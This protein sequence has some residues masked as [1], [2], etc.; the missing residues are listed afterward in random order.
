[1]RRK[2]LWRLAMQLRL[3]LFVLGVFAL[4]ALPAML[5][6]MARVSVAA[7]VQGYASR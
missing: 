6:E 3:L 2:L 7:A 4:F 5:S 1:M